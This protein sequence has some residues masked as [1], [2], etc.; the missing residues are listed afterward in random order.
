MNDK[1]KKL[2]FEHDGDEGAVVTLTADNGSALDVQ[3]MAALEMESYGKEYLA[4]VPVEATEQY[5]EDQL[6][7]LA[8]SEDW[9]GK[10]QFSGV[11]DEQE[12][13]EVAEIFLQQLASENE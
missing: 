5:P 8:Y 7:I 13:E 3:V 6:I 1:N 9:K 4:V 10:P 2:F 12:L 11:S